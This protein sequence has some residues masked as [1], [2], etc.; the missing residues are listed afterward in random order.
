MK[1]IIRLIFIISFCIFF[2]PKA[3]HAEFIKELSSTIEVNKDGTID[4]SE[5]INYDFETLERHGII[6]TIPELKVNQDGKKYILDLTDISVT[7][8]SKNPY[9]F[10][11]SK[12]NNNLN[13]KIG[14]PERTITGLHTYIINYKVK[15]ELTY[16]SDHDEL[17]WNVTGN[18]WNVPISTA[19]AQINLPEEINADEMR[20]ECFTGPAGDRNKDCS[21]EIKNNIVTIYST[22]PLSSTEGLT[23]VVG[24]PKNI[25]A[26][27]E[28]K[29]YVP[30][31]ETFIGK[32]LF[33]VL[34]FIGLLVSFFWYIIYPFKIIYKWYRY[35]RDPRGTLGVVSV[36]FDPPKT[37]KGRELTPAETGTLIDEK[38]DMQ[39]VYATIVDLARRG[40]LKIREV[41]K[42]DFYIDKLKSEESSL[43]PHE[44]KL[45]KEF[46]DGKESIHIK[47]ASL[48][49]EIDE[50]KKSIYEEMVDEKFFPENPNNIRTFYSVIGILALTTGNI[51]LCIIAF[52]FGRNVPRKTILGSEQANVAKSLKNFLSSQ[53]RQLEFQAKNQMFFEKL[54]PYAVAFGVEDIWAKRFKDIA[55][56]QPSW[57]EGYHGGSFN[58]VIFANSLNQSFSKVQSAATATSSSSGFS[59]GFSGGSS[60]GGGGG[61]GG[62]SW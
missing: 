2:F 39:D 49:A 53:E 4:V 50:V 42:N 12:E 43:Q 27:V 38:V 36:W 11:K 41:K 7:D 33:V 26:I 54:L 5:R 37:G 44:I 29:E 28:P 17:Y 58:S 23:A 47:N 55:L 13:I 18:D 24:F 8:E 22:S 45:L 19:S 48:V 16:F 61:G 62:G 20:I 21:F 32:I 59:S 40:Y 3:S 6:R 30:F 9:Q 57:Y 14:D 51:F 10:T 31:W 35:G 60:G 56:K 34:V 52:L 1:K 25:V 46:F 15:G